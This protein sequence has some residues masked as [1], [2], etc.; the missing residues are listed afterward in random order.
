[1]KFLLL[2]AW[3][4]LALFTSCSEAVKHRIFSKEN[5]DLFDVWWQF[6]AQ[7]S[8]G[9]KQLMDVYFGAKGEYK[10]SGGEQGKWEWTVDNTMKIK[11]ASN[12][13]LIQFTHL[14]SLEMRCIFGEDQQ[15]YRFTKAPQ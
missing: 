9:G 13:W 4:S 15:E 11:T 5:K 7:S 12:Q 1:M 10:S 14:D 6:D 8:P 2:S 3:L